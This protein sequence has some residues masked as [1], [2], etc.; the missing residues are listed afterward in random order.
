MSKPPTT[1]FTSSMT[2]SYSSYGRAVKWLDLDAPA[3]T[4]ISTRDFNTLEN[5]LISMKP[6]PKPW[7]KFLQGPMPDLD[8]AIREPI[9][10]NAFGAVVFATKTVNKAT[11]KF[12]NFLQVN[13]QQQQQTSKTLVEECRKRRSSAILPACEQQ[14]ALAWW[15]YALLL[16]CFDRWKRG[17]RLIVWSRRRPDPYA[18][19]SSL[20]VDSESSIDEV[21]NSD[22]EN[23][24]STA[25][26]SNISNI[27]KNSN[28][29]ELDI[30][31]IIELRT[32]QQHFKKSSMFDVAI[33]DPMFEKA[34]EFVDQLIHTR[35][36]FVKR[37]EYNVGDPRLKWTVSMKPEKLILLRIRFL[38]VRKQ[39]EMK[40]ALVEQ[41]RLLQAERLR[42]AQAWIVENMKLE[43]KKIQLRIAEK[44]RML[45]V[46]RGQTIEDIFVAF[47]LDGG[48]T[49]DPD[50][51][52]DG[53]EALNIGLNEHGT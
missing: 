53:F 22:D 37:D 10:R 30:Q 50:E 18:T 6:A 46:D 44:F 49:I 40:A 17:I 9:R 38:K 8:L 26:L 41:K 27:S 51:L 7:D 11:S 34:A 12:K 52:K 15:V 20:L 43:Q 13:R 19:Y 21:L 45:K 39:Q 47:D 2:R 5:S 23:N 36:Q 48:G 31:D 35:R 42:R 32:I 14:K 29:N 25:N 24:T 16:K 33:S 3:I 4:I 1:F 28:T